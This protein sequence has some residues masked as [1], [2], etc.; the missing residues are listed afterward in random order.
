[1][2]FRTQADLELLNDD[3]HQVDKNGRY[4]PV[5]YTDSYFLGD[6]GS[7]DVFS[8]F[9]KFSH[10]TFSMLFLGG[11]CIEGRI[12]MFNNL[13]E[14]I[15]RKR[16][17]RFY[18]REMYFVQAMPT[19]PLYGIDVTSFDPTT[20]NY[21]SKRPRRGDSLLYSLAFA[22]TA[23]AVETEAETAGNLGQVPRNSDSFYNRLYAG[24]F[25]YLIQS[26]KRLWFFDA[27]SFA[28]LRE[29]PYLLQMYVGSFYAE[30][31]AS[32]SSGAFAVGATG[33]L[34]ALDPVAPPPS[35]PFTK[36]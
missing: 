33:K 26:G 22:D 12:D 1:M 30:T 14:W 21:F 24:E 29:N 6:L 20:T 5:D 9:K 23:T 16:I 8:I 18:P 17:V 2:P 35:R 28:M 11:I 10:D 36:L 13:C 7:L 19:S 3:L 34:I 4:L 31:V 27:A 32:I 25:C 15:V